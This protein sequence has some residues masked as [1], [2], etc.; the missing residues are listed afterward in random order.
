MSLSGD[1]PLDNNLL[2]GKS[3]IL[4]G[5]IAGLYP[6][7]DKV[8]VQHL[9]EIAKESKAFVIALSESHLKSHILDAEVHIPGFQLFRADRKDEIKKGGVITFVKEEFAC[10]IE[11]LASG[12]N[13]SAEWN[14]LFLPVIRS[15]VINVY[16]PPSCTEMKCKEMLAEISAAI[17]M[18]SAPMPTI[19]IC[20]DFNLPII[21]WNTGSSTGVPLICR[22]K[23][24]LSLS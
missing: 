5:N 18:I 8:K 7:T 20:G 24:M 21:N 22:G 16:R 13:G 14:C 2:T 23:L 6:S 12:C 11:V 10:G 4:F 3:S 1:I 17:E 15:V 9:G 19:M